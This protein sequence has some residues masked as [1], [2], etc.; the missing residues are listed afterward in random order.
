VH[1][2]LSLIY[3]PIPRAVGL[4]KKIGNSGARAWF[5]RMARRESVPE[6]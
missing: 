2:A 6:V 4:Q 5:N 1:V 3:N